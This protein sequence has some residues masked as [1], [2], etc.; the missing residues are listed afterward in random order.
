M[1]AAKVVDRNRA[2]FDASYLSLRQLDDYIAILLI[3]GKEVYLDPG[4]KMCP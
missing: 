3:D 4:Q 1:W 2:I